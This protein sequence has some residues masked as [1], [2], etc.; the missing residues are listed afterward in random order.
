VDG[1]GVINMVDVI[2]AFRI[3][4]GTVTPTQNQLQAAN[5]DGKEGVTMVDVILLFQ[6][7]ASN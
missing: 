3:A 4:A 2:F 5:T 1:N 7:V 6:Q